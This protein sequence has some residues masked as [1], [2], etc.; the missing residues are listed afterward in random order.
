MTSN[1]RLHGHHF[2]NCGCTIFPIR[3]LAN[4]TGLSF[5]QVWDCLR[6][7][8]THGSQL[9]MHFT[10]GTTPFPI[11]SCLASRVS[12]TALP[13]SNLL[14][15]VKAY[16][17]QRSKTSLFWRQLPRSCSSA[18]VS[19][20]VLGEWIQL[21][22]LI[23]EWPCQSKALTS[24]L[25]LPRRNLVGSFSAEGQRMSC[26][27]SNISKKINGSPVDVRRFAIRAA[28]WRHSEYLCLS[29]KNRRNTWSKW[30]WTIQGTCSTL[31]RP[32]RQSGYST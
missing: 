4:T 28:P 21:S 10:C 23:R 30:L 9:T 2:R 19:E 8:T 13:L 6:N 25:S 24:L 15:L 17:F 14:Y 22:S 11:L 1:P 26:M 27:N 32:G 31:Y 12:P 7:C 3:Y 18:S 16:F 29:A 5:Q 20:K